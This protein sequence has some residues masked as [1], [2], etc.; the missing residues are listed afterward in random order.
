MLTPQGG[1]AG[2]KIQHHLRSAYGYERKFQPPPRH[3]RLPPNRRHSEQPSRMSP[4]DAV[5]GAPYGILARAVRP[6]AYRLS[7]PKESL[8]IAP[9]DCTP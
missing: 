5:E 8:A 6:S 9:V 3:V 2:A 1:A 7:D 4:F